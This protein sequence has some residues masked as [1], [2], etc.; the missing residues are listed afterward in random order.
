MFCFVIYG[1]AKLCS[2][3]EI[4]HWYLHSASLRITDLSLGPYVSYKLKIVFLS[5]LNLCMVPQELGFSPAR[6]L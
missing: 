6:V 5:K 2:L 4:V 1:E 3:L